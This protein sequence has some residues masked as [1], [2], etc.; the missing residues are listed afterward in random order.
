MLGCKPTGRH[1]EQHDV[2]FGIA[3]TL[4]ELIPAIQ[5][6]WPEA[7]D[8]IHIDAWREVKAVDG[9]LIEV[10][11]VHQSFKNENNLFFINLGGYRPGEF[12]EPHY[13]MLVC[14][15]DKASAIKQAKETAFY[16]HTKFAGA[17]SHVDDKYGIDVDDLFSIEDVLPKALKEKY[18]LKITEAKDLE[19][20]VIHLGYF[21]LN[22][23]T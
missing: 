8:K 23:L 20:D 2:F 15:G 1:T 21:R 4:K 5:E 18:R 3:S 16:K 12:D 17:D 13:R 11:D 9:F 10:V 22:N 7:Q 19:E 6:F 14:T